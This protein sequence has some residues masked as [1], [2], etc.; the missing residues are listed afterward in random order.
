MSWSSST[1]WNTEGWNRSSGAISFIGAGDV[2][3][4]A[5]SWWG[6]RAYTL[7]S[8]GGNA[9][10]LRR[11]S[12]NT[13]Q[14]FVTVTG[15]GLDL[16]S[17]ITFKST[18]NLFVDTLYD[19]TG[20]TVHLTQATNS[21]QPAFI[22]SAVGALPSIQFDSASSQELANVTA[23]AGSTLCGVQN[24]TN[25]GGQQTVHGMSGGGPRVGFNNS[26][27]NTMFFYQGA[28]LTVGS[29]AD[30]SWH[31][32]VGV[33]NGASGVAYVDASTTSGAV[34]ANTPGGTVTLGS[35]GGSEFFKGSILEFGIWPGFFNATQAANMISNQKTYYGI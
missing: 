12:D 23:T 7:S 35:N 15:G 26:G 18:A 8:I 13:T 9:I 5:T 3:A 16:A 28:L 4:S 21:K 24:S 17:I 30:G 25:T 34:G 20:G 14:N 29:I 27:A 6:T 22:L 32:S 11:D 1:S 31:E 33:F 10:K 2:V 19:Q